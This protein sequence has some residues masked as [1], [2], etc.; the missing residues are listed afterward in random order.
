MLGTSHGANDIL[1]VDVG[2][3]KGHDLIKFSTK[4]PS[5]R[6]RLVLQDLPSV[7]QNLEG[8]SPGI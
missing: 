4:Y 2:G 3:G 6:G 8:L 5:A 7:I 1:L